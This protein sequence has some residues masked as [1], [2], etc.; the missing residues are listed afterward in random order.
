MKSVRFYPKMKKGNKTL[1]IYD[2][3]TPIKNL[4]ISEYTVNELLHGGLVISEYEEELKNY[5]P[6]IS[7]KKKIKL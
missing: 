3:N 7:L 5:S 4:A 1:D 2:F 6:V